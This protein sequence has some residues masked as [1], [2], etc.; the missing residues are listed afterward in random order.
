[1]YIKIFYTIIQNSI[2]NSS[3]PQEQEQ[4]RRW[5]YCF[6]WSW[7]EQLW[8]LG[9][10][11]E[12]IQFTFLKSSREFV[13]YFWCLILH[14]N[15]IR[16]QYPDIWLSM[17]R[18]WYKGDFSIGLT[19]KLWIDYSLKCEWASSKTVEGLKKTPRSPG[20]WKFCQQTAFRLKL[21]HQQ[22]LFPESPP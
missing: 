19:F 2:A 5:A 12:G 18:C 22:Q 14:V 7:D 21:Q 20:K 11:T 13:A 4:K 6:C 15:L 1:M 16:T 10:T 17:S 3:R 8:T 9:K